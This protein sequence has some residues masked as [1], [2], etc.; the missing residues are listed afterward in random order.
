MRIHLLAI[1]S[2][3]VVPVLGAS[4]FVA[5]HLSEASAYSLGRGPSS[6]HAAR[7]QIYRLAAGDDLQSALNSAKAGDTIELD[8]G[9]TF[10]GSFTLPE[11]PDQQASSGPQWITVTTDSS[12]LPG[13]GTRVSPGDAPN[14]A[15]ILS[16]GSQAAIQT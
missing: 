16:P 12:N 13:P 5:N 2:L 14:M 15:K 9:A 3:L 11:K 4:A 6:I 8:P 10:V 7:G 1:S